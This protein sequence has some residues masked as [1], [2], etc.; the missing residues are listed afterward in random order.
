VCPIDQTRKTLNHWLVIPWII[1]AAGMI[2]TCLGS[3][4]TFGR[5]GFGMFLSGGRAQRSRLYLKRP[6]V[7]NFRAVGINAPPPTFVSW[8][9]LVPQF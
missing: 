3:V 6:K 5:D 1:P 8:V 9:L 2:W 4:V 7:Q